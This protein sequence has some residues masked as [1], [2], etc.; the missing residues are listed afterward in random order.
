[1]SI[2]KELL[3][4]VSAVCFSLHLQAQV[5][6]GAGEPPHD[7]AL[8]D[9]KENRNGTATK[10]LLFPRVSLEAANLAKP[11]KSHVAGMTVYNYANSPKGTSSEN[12]I[13]PGFYYNTGKRW[14]RLNIGATNWFYMPSVAINT[15]TGS[16]K[17]PVNLYN[18]YKSQFTSPVKASDGAP[19]FIPYIPE[20]DD[21][22]YYVTDVDPAITVKSISNEGEMLYE[23]TGATTECSYINIIFVLK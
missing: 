6:I 4:F 15:E 14:E 11:M 18:L 10:G 21:L 12:Y 19:A 17:P 7:D 13:S 9:L 5:T 2:K 3:L 20:A 22:Y 23:V 1:M 8:L 16:N